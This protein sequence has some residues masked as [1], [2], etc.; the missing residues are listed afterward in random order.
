LRGLV[1]AELE[2]LI[3]ATIARLTGQSIALPAKP[4]P[5]RPT[6]AAAQKSPQRKRKRSA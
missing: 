5:V 1:Q 4:L 2:P 6:L 3:E